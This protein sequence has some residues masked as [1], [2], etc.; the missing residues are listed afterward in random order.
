M[1][2][3]L[4]R[5]VAGAFLLAVLQAPVLAADPAAPAEAKPAPERVQ[6]IGQ[7]FDFV[8]GKDAVY[9]LRFIDAQ[10]LEVT[11]MADPDPDTA[12]GTV[13]RLEVAMTELRPDVYMV[14]W[15]D[16]DTGSTVTHV[17]DFANK[18]AYAN[19]T[20]LVSEGFARLKGE[21]RPVTAAASP[22]PAV[23]APSAPPAPEARLPVV[24]ASVPA[25]QAGTTAT[26]AAL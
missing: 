21:I 3:K 15:V 25:S 14:T 9:R 7:Q 13:S 20:N 11:V 22:A 19:T 17:E 5:A 1:S 12:P 4:M 26:G 18:V 16:P 2:Y 24:P 6:I 23:A 10:H 8:F